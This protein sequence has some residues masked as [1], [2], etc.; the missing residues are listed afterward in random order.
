MTLSFGCHHPTQSALDAA[1]TLAG[2]RFAAAEPPRTLD[3][4]G[5]NYQ[6]ILGHN[7]TLPVCTVVGLCNAMLAAEALNA[8][9]GLPID[10]E[11]I[12]PFYASVAGCADTPAAIIATDGVN[13]LDVL[14][15]QLRG[16]DCGLQTPSVGLFGVLPRTRPMLA[17]AIDKLGSAYVGIDLYERDMDAYEGGHDWFDWQSDPGRL[18]SGHLIPTWDYLGLGDD[19]T[20]R[21]ATWGVLQ[22]FTMGWLFNRMRSMAGLAYR[23][24]GTA[25]ALDAGGDALAAELDAW[26]VG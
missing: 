11:K 26:R 19:D 8:G 5:I 7:D 24:L 14:N 23:F 6:P 2:H 3:R 25:G 12:A 9:A 20:G 1:P 21:A 17:N 16:F 22:V 4:R 10:Q 18:V 13:S 15:A